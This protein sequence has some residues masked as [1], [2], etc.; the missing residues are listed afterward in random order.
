[1]QRNAGSPKVGNY[2]G[3]GVFNSRT[4]LT[5]VRQENKFEVR[6][7]KYSTMA[8][9]SYVNSSTNPESKLIK[10]DNNKF[11]GLYKTLTEA[12]TITVAYN[13]IK[14]KPGNMTAT[15]G[16]DETVTLDEMSNTLL[17]SM[18]N[19]LQDGS[20][21]FKPARRVLIPKSNGKMRAL[22]ISSPRDKI[23]QEAM[24]MLLE[25]IFEPSFSQTSHGFRPARGCHTAL[26]EISK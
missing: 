8:S 10:L 2:Y 26:K 20:F 1:M 3:D 16:V 13:N 17:T 4:C 25:A 24:R 14:S 18:A 6:Q 9:A 21:Q 19:S 23:I 11:T 12:N 15:P 7:Y 5:L 22:A